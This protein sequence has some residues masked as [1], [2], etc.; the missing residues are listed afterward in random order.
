M[1]RTLRHYSGAVRDL[2]A[3]RSCLKIANTYIITN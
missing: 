3:I 1:R 2:Q